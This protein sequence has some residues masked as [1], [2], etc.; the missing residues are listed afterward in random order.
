M[1]EKKFPTQ[2]EAIRFMDQNG[3]GYKGRKGLFTKYHCYQGV[4]ISR[5]LDGFTGYTDRDNVDEFTC[6]VHA[7]GY[8]KVCVS[9]KSSLCGISRIPDLVWSDYGIY[10]TTKEL[11]WLMGQE[12][13]H[14][15]I[16]IVRQK[17]YTFFVGEEQHSFEGLRPLYEF[18]KSKGFVTG[19][20]P[21]DEL[22]K[23]AMRA[24]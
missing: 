10:K 19:D 23:K 8:I 17:Q 1:F 3:W 13:D 5:S 15:S 21:F 9:F 14:G 22:L 11:V 4:T 6:E 12:L 20:T 18:A 7:D 2:E 16:S 24:A